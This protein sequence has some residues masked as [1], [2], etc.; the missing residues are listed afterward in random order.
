MGKL[1]GKAVRR[2]RSYFKE[3]AIWPVL[4]AKGGTVQEGD[5]HFSDLQKMANNP[6]R[7]TRTAASLI[8]DVTCIMVYQRTELGQKHTENQQ[9]RRTSTRR[10]QAA[11]KEDRRFRV[12]KV[13]EEIESLVANDELREVWSKI[14]R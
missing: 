9:E 5:S 10:F 13:G 8:S 1:I 4:A 3:Q 12:R 7:N 11:L 2:H 14:Q 6:S